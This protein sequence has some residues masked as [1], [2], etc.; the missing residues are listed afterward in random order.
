MSRRG[1]FSRCLLLLLAA[2]LARANTGAADAPPVRRPEAPSTPVGKDAT[3]TPIKHPTESVPAPGE[4]KAISETPL[5]FEAL[6]FPGGK[7]ILICPD[8][9]EA[10]QLTPKA[11]VMTVEEYQR[12]LE[13]IEQLKRQNKSDK[14]INPS[15][16]RVTGRIV[17]DMAE[18][19]MRFQFRTERASTQVNLGCHKGWPTDVR[20][21]GEL[22]FLQDSEDGYALAV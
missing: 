7:I 1:A 4:K 22:A 5:P 6:K 13:Q 19:Q 2:L 8:V 20:L 9:K 14:P 10:L 12:L 16:C 21:D 17:E 18:L 3:K 11:V 15:I